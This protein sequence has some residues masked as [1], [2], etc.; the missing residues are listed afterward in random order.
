MSGE[1]DDSGARDSGD[2]LDRD[3]LR[4]AG[5]SIPGPDSDDAT[6][7]EDSDSAARP[8][9]TPCPRCGTPIAMVTARG[10]DDAR[11]SPCGC[12]VHG[13]ILDDG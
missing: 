4:A 10:P 8:S 6:A 9:P 5:D 1:S 12:R 3:E 2:R 11:A 7:G 13:G